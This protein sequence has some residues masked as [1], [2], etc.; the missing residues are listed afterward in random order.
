MYLEIFHVM[1][2]VWHV[3]RGKG[4][5]FTAMMSDFERYKPRKYAHD[6]SQKLCHLLP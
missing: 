1:P 6:L 5:I 2:E 4:F 3:F